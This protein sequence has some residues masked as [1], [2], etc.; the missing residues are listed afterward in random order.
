MPLMIHSAHD[1]G[2]IVLISDKNSCF[3][4]SVKEIHICISYKNVNVSH[5]V[6]W[7]INST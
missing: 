1:G 5:D 4:T 7:S 2:V 3:L 6:L